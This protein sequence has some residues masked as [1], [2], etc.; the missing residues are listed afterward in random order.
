MT[1]QVCDANSATSGGLSH[2]DH[3]NRP[4]G[5]SNDSTNSRQIKANA[6]S[7]HRQRVLDVA[8][9]MTSS[10]SEAEDIAQETSIRLLEADL[11]TIEDVVGW[12]VTVASRLS[13][14]RLRL[15]E[16]SR[17]VYVGPWLPEPLVRAFDD[18]TADRVTLDDTV[19]MALLIVLDRMTPAERTAFV[20]HDV[21]ALPFDEI[22]EIVGRSPQAV[23]QLATRARRRVSADPLAA[24]QSTDHEGH[25]ELAD[26]FARACAGGDL[27]DLISLLAEDVIGDFDS[28]GLIPN[29]PLTELEGP[30]SVARQL[31]AVMSSVGAG[32]ETADIN[33]SP[34]VVVR[35]GDR[36]AAVISFG[37]RD[38]V[39][40]VV[41]GVGN[42]A[43]LAHVV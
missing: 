6:W 4:I 30:E 20:L 14:D 32:F 24:R 43:K 19:R 27:E 36:L 37:I 41:H 28:G 39:I 40:D 11:S 17:R 42:P 15:H 25:L 10:V 38:G 34:G 18:D 16:N 31:I 23:R 7:Q 9:R 21:F 5:M 3:L 2:F 8:Y 35:I 26:R 12:L 13:I 29:A 33:G 22:A 1:P